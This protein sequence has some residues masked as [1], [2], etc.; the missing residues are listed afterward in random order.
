MTSAGLAC[1]FAAI[2]GRAM[3]AIAVSSDA[4]ARAVKIA[5]AAHFRY[6]TCRSPIALGLS[7][8]MFPV[9]IQKVSDIRDV[10]L[11]WSGS[12]RPL[13]AAYAI[14]LNIF[15]LKK[16]AMRGATMLVA[17]AF[18]LYIRRVQKL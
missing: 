1:S 3:F 5:K 2:A 8:E 6:F 10:V 12:R 17:R 4:I 11:S 13:D 7:A 9:D 14:S 16:S 15:V 18:G